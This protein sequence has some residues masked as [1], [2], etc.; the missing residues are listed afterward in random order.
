MQS[1]AIEENP[2]L[3]CATETWAHKD[4]SDAELN[5][6][7]YVIRNDRDEESVEAVLYIYEKTSTLSNVRNLHQHITQKRYGVALLW[8]Q[9]PTY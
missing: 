2:D 4:I 9:G 8:I 5:L 7:R 3:I 1:V 6:E